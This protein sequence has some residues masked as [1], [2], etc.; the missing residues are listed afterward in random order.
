MLFSPVHCKSG[1][2]TSET[3]K[4]TVNLSVGTTEP[5]HTVDEWGRPDPTTAVMVLALLSVRVQEWIIILAPG[6]DLQSPGISCLTGM[7]V[8]RGA[9][10]QDRASMP[11]V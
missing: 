6:R 1:R 10:G 7:F 3:A 11:T 2:K 5:G 4:E 8:Y 9:S